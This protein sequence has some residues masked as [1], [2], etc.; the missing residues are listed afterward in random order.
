M[1]H[2]EGG[3]YVDTHYIETRPGL[4]EDEPRD[5]GGLMRNIPVAGSD[6]LERPSGDEWSEMD[7]PAPYGTYTVGRHFEGLS[8]GMHL[9]I[10]YKED[11]SS[12]S[13]LCRGSLVYREVMGEI[14]CYVPGDEWEGWIN[15]LS[16]SAKD[17]LRK[18]KE[19]EFSKRVEEAEKTKESWWRSMRSRWGVT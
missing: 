3:P 17:L 1:G 4:D 8:R 7:D 19:E 14:S 15:R 11:S 18:S 2:S 6:G 12:L 10:V 13:V 16:R 9:E 5:A